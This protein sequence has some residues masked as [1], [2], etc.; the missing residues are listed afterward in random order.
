MA[1]KNIPTHRTQEQHDKEI[2]DGQFPALTKLQRKELKR[3]IDVKLG[4][5]KVIKD[6]VLF[7]KDLKKLI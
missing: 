7:I 5:A 4:K 6:L 2:I 1:Q 3:E